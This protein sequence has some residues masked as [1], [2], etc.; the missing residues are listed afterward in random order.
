MIKAA[1]GMLSATALAIAITPT[2][3]KADGLTDLNQAL[4]NLK[5]QTPI[6]ATLESSHS[7]NRDRDD[8]QKTT[9]GYIA[10]NLADGEPGLQIT[11]GPEMLAKLEHEEILTDEDEEADT[12]TFNAMNRLATTELNRMLSAAPSLS[13]FINKAEF[14]EET[15]TQYQQQDARRL[16]FDLPLESIV[17]SAEVR[18]YVDDFEGKYTLILNAQGVPQQSILTFSGSGSAF[19]IFSVEMEQTNTITYRQHGD[20]L[21]VVKEE[22][23]RSSSSTFADTESTEIKQLTIVSPDHLAKVN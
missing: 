12:P 15:A 2:A 3:V 23:Q 17:D 18:D 8:D 5:G 9:T 16:I 14:V 6:R 19:V 7:Q 21:V 22:T 11:Y 13:R 1:L 10:L 4:S 20:R